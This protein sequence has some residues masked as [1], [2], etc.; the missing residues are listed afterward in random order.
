MKEKTK[1]EEI[2]KSFEETKDD[3]VPTTVKNEDLK[4]RRLSRYYTVAYD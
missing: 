2:K 3:D 1:W 4:I